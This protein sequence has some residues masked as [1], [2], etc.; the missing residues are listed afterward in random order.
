[1]SLAKDDEDAESHFLHRSDRMNSQGIAEDAKCARFCL[2]LVVIP[3]S[4]MNQSS[5]WAMAGISYETF[6]K[7]V[8][9]IRTHT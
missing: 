6:F 2:L 9:L 7:T 5:L 3:I 8:L 1:M 4:S